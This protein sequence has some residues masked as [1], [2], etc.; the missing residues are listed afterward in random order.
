MI[1]N[2]PCSCFA[3][4]AGYRNHFEAGLPAILSGEITKC[5]YSIFNLKQADTEGAIIFDFADGIFS[6]HGTGGSFSESIKNIIVAVK[7]LAG[8]SKETVAGLCSSR[9][10]TYAGEV[11]FS[12]LDSR[13]SIDRTCLYY[14][15]QVCN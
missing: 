9:V 6:Y 8:Y 5:F 12:I 13:Y 10:D 15:G 11:R 2:V 4:R 3:Y 7:I 14:S 1:G